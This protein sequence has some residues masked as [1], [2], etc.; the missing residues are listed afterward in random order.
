[1]WADCYLLQPSICA[2][3]TT[4]GTP[5]DDTQSASFNTIHPVTLATRD[6]STVE[7]VETLSLGRLKAIDSTPK[8]FAWKVA[9]DASEEATSAIEITRDAEAVHEMLKVW[10]PSDASYHNGNDR[11]LLFCD[12]ALKV[13]D[14]IQATRGVYQPWVQSAFLTLQET[15][16]E[17]VAVSARYVL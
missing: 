3:A 15:E 12:I 10:Q 5:T 14:A 4:E 11:T 1:M 6:R 13:F 2:T 8:S 16:R 17:P 7:T 9:L